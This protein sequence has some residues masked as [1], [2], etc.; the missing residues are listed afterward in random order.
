MKDSSRPVVI[1]AMNAFRP[2]GSQTYAFALARMLTDRGVQPVLVGK[3]G[4]WFR[5]ASLAAPSVRVIWREGT[6]SGDVHWMKKPLLII[7][8]AVSA[9]YLATKY[10]NAALILSSQPGPTA[11][12]SKYSPRYWPIAKRAA[13]VH[14]TTPV[15]W[16]FYDHAETISKLHGLFAATSETAAFLNSQV[17]NI[18]VNELGNIFSADMYWGP[19]ITEIIGNYDSEGPAVFLGTLTPNKTAPLAA[20]FSAVEKINQRLV[21]VGGGPEEGRLRRLVQENGLQSNV[22]FIGA[23][24]DPK[25]WIIKASVVIT[26]G[27]GAIESMSAGRPTI[28]A[29][30]DGTHGLARLSGLEELRRYNFTGRTPSSTPPTHQKMSQA[31]AD[32]Q[33]LSEKERTAIAR[34]MSAVGSIEPV[35]DAILNVV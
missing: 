21:V 12:F 17:T 26:A 7:L 16:P 14:G 35:M 29:T 30:S 5:E 27:R 23:V 4:A 31:L 11:F 10:R 34:A 20:L 3:P 24:T 13:L 25:P 18:C 6:A 33:A 32:A 28:V 9:R 1:I 8:E 2:G 19:G 15:E 22:D